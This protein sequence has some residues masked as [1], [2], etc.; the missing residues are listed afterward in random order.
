MAAPLSRRLQR[1]FTLRGSFQGRMR[2][3]SRRS[4]PHQVRLWSGRAGSRPQRQEVPVLLRASTGT[5]TIL[6]VIIPAIAPVTCRCGRS[7]TSEPRTSSKA[8]R[9]IPARSQGSRAT[10]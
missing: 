2:A 6:H 9:Q 10:R 7:G 8:Q 1:T 5:A 4:L 3:L